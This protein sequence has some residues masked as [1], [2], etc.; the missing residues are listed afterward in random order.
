MDTEIDIDITNFFFFFLQIKKSNF[1]KFYLFHDLL[2]SLFLLLP[3]VIVRIKSMEILF[4]DLTEIKICLYTLI[5]VGGFF[6]C[7]II[8]VIAYYSEFQY[9]RFIMTFYHVWK[10]LISFSSLVVCIFILIVIAI[11]DSNF[12]EYVIEN[13]KNPEII[14]NVEDN[15]IPYIV[16]ASFL[17]FYSIINLVNSF[18]L[19]KIIKNVLQGDDYISP[20]S[21]KSNKRV[22]D[23]QK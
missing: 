8:C 9:N 19:I 1:C 10:I 23:E 7:L 11:F 4:F 15:F 22:F 20:G 5:S 14:K 18:R 12:K 16:I 6:L 3:P 21:E 13:R 2:W 17:S